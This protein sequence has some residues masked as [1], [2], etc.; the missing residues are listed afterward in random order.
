MQEVLVDRGQLVVEHLVE[1]LDDL[2]ITFHG[3]L[4]SWT[5]AT[6][7]NPARR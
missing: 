7:Q 4:P 2:G 5:A 1:E 6:I 3:F